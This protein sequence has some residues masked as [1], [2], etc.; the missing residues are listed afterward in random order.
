MTDARAAKKRDGDV[1]LGCDD[2]H[3]GRATSTYLRL[4]HPQ[5]VEVRVGVFLVHPLA[6]VRGDEPPHLVVCEEPGMLVHAVHNV[7]SR[8]GKKYRPV[9]Q[10][11]TSPF[12]LLLSSCCTEAV[13]GQH[14]TE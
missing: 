9:V 14:S 13:E 7:R 3:G 10:A 8:I 5:V 1:R 12:Q 2:E 6:P 11:R 4:Y